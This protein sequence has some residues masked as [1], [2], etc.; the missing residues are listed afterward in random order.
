M[1]VFVTGGSGFVGS[2]VVGVLV[3]AHEVLAMARSDRSAAAVEALGA[4][5]VRCELGAVRPEDL[6]GVDAIVH[7]A[8]FV[9][10]WGT[11]AAYERVNVEGT[12]QL[13]DA[14]RQAG[15]RRFVHVGTEAAL[16][17]GADLVDVDEAAPYP[18]RHR[19]LYSETKAA[20]EALVL[21]ANGPGFTTLSVRP[22]LVWGD[23]DSTIL[24]A[25]RR[26]VEVGGFLWL[27]HGR[28]RTSTTHV[29]NLAHAIAL[30]LGSG[31]GGEAYF[32]VDDGQPTLREFLTE[33]AAAGGI[34]LPD[35]SV[36][37]AVARPLSSVVEGAWRALRLQGA[38]PI[39]AFAAHMMSRTVTVR[40][41]KARAELGYRPVLSRGDG[42]RALR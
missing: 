8:A 5:A 1:R 30:A 25:L 11:R 3:D 10:E 26:M 2:H 14:A 38:P 16:F 41:D 12:R 31:R 36:P 32:V 39:T 42:L 34:E 4:T 9:E 29:S 20:A 27:D 15:V 22:R 21:A 18:A 28:H 19:F 37:G 6:A 23:R 13:L 7:A 24:P 33:Y 35:R 17:D 40:D